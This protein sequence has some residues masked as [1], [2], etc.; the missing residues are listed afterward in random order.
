MAEVDR[1]TERLAGSKKYRSIHRDTIHDIA[2]G[3]AANAFDARDL[4]RLVRQRLH[5]AVAHFLVSGTTA[6]VAEEIASLPADPRDPQL[7]CWCRRV[8]AMHVSSAERLDDLDEFYG[9]L[10]ELVGP[11]DSVADVAC[12]F[13]T[14]ALPAEPGLAVAVYTAEP[15]SPTAE[16]LALLASWAATDVPAQQAAP[17]EKA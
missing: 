14:M 6:K 9:R 11:V 1:L 10:L 13:N 15:G 2:A 7:R 17:A 5:R 12:A 8:M 4:E 16:K 3:E